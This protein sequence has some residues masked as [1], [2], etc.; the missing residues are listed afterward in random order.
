M[1]R[2][3]R[4]AVTVDN[5]D[6][7]EI[8]NATERLL[9]EIITLNNVIAEDV[10]HVLITVTED[11]NAT[12]PAKALRSLQG[13]TY[14]PV[15]CSREIPVPDSLSNCIRVMLTVNT[16]APQRE[17]KHVYLEKAIQLRPD[18]QLTDQ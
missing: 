1:V 11:L 18:L 14:V 13:W 7:K 8:V 9:L 6:E 5:N 12:F 15:M 16:N 4:G 3:I 10:A 17:I 2:G